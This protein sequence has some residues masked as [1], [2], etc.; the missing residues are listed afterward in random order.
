MPT[1]TKHAME[2]VVNRLDGIIIGGEAV[3]HPS[4]VAEGSIRRI[5]VLLDVQEMPDSLSNT[6][7]C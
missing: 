7:V 5:P 3:H 4:V 1:A 6:V 2:R